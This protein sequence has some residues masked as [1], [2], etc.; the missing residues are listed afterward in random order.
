MQG[1]CECW[2]VFRPNA[3]STEQQFDFQTDPETCKCQTLPTSAR[4]V[5][6][7]DDIKRV[8]LVH[9]KGR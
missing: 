8:D 1:V 2:K 7:E 4:H 9:R 5:V 6:G 3:A